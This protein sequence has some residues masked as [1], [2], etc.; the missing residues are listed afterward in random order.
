MMQDGT[1][2]HPNSL[3]IPLE[4]VVVSL[5]M[6]REKNLQTA[7]TN[8]VLWWTRPWS[9]MYMF[10]IWF[11]RVCFIMNIL[12]QQ[13]SSDKSFCCRTHSN[14]VWTKTFHI[15]HT[16][17]SGVNRNTVFLGN[18]YLHICMVL[19]VLFCMFLFNK[20]LFQHMFYKLLLYEKRGI[21]QVL[22]S[23]LICRIC[24]VFCQLALPQSHF[25]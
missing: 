3:V 25:P 21:F 11:F 6:D 12:S 10:T 24:I 19:D 8:A 14:N 23:N 16:L 1:M 7:C 18:I 15:N 13:C 4:Y 9:L 22:C 17:N 5:L 2:I 20:V